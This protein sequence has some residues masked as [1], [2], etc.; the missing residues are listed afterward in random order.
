MILFTLLLSLIATLAAAQKTCTSHSDCPG[1]FCQFPTGPVGT[2]APVGT[3]TVPTSASTPTLVT[4]ISNSTVSLGGCPTG[5]L[6]IK[7]VCT[8]P[9]DEAKSFF[10]PTVIAIIIGV[11]VL[12]LGLCGCWICCCCNICCFA[13]KTAS[14]ATKGVVKGGAAIIAAPFSGSKRSEERSRN[15]TRENSSRN[16]YSRTNAPAPPAD[17]YRP[18]LNP[19]TRPEKSGPAPLPANYQAPPK[20]YEAPKQKYAY[21]EVVEIVPIAPPPQQYASYPVPAPPVQAPAPYQPPPQSYDIPQSYPPQNYPQNYPPQNYSP[22]YNDYA[23]PS[24]YNSPPIVRQNSKSTN[25][26][27]QRAE[28]SVKDL[29]NLKPA[30]IP[31]S[32]PYKPVMNQK[33]GPIVSDMKRPP[34]TPG[35]FGFWDKKGKFHQGFTD[36]DNFVH[37]GVFDDQGFFHFGVFGSVEPILVEDSMMATERVAKTETAVSLSERSDV[38]DEP[39]VE[40]KDVRDAISFD[41]TYRGSFDVQQK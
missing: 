16:D 40:V 29:G 14:K 11:A 34:T 28:N 33:V 23:Q 25:Y 4:C 39:R 7:Q 36:D 1:S 15:N 35:F 26:D 13:G 27:S 2:C 8:S 5:Q 37:G 30:G 24:S 38:H 41:A 10:S 6:C 18:Q 20:Q 32:K 12:I 3:A 31:V 21:E 9:V 17:D 19:A 22:Q